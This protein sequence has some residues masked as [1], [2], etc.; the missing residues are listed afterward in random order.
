M[1]LSSEQG[2]PETWSAESSNIKWRVAIPGSGNSSPIVSR[3]RVFLTTAVK[4][5]DGGSQVDRVCLAVDF[6]TGEIL[7]HTPVAT[8]PA[9]T[10]HRLNTT[11]GPTPATDGELVFAYFG[12]VLAALDMDGR[13]VWKNEVDPDY[14]KYSRYAAASSPTLTADAVIVIQDRE[15]ADTED[16][17]WLAAFEKKTGRQIWRRDWNETCCSYSSPLIVE[18][19]SGPRLLFAHSGSVEEYDIS[20]GETLW[21]HDVRLNQMVSSIVADEDLLCVAGGAHH[22]RGAA[23]WR[24]SGTGKDTEVEVLWESG[25][26]APETASPIL[27]DGKFFMVT[28]KGILSCLDPVSGERLWRKRLPQSG[29]HVSPVAGDGKV[30]VSNARGLTTVVAVKPKL[31]VIAENTLDRGGTAS[32]AIAGGSLLIRTKTHLVRIEKGEEEGATP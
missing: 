3:G 9:E 4:D 10:R 22:V 13:I 17:G 1:G 15:Y 11:A 29:Y 24:L 26:G 32:P 14:A 8:A 7:W 18:Q 12:A 28:N 30:Y 6:E 23:C 27:Y 20:S 2:L 31:R 5:P 16:L 25:H 19:V 21:S